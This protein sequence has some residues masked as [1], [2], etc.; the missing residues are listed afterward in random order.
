MRRC[1]HTLICIRVCLCVCVCKDYPEDTPEDTLEDTPNGDTIN[2]D[3]ESIYANSE[4][5]APTSNT[6]EMTPMNKQDDVQ[7][8][9]PRHTSSEVGY[10]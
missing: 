6:I 8:T 7:S 10:Y 5:F 1:G 2:K 9:R 4:E 3:T